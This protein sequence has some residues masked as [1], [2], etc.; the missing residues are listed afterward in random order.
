[1]IKNLVIVPARAGSIRLSNKNIAML[2]NKPLF[3][4]TINL[5]KKLK[6]Y[7]DVIVSTDCKKIIAFCKNKNY[8][9]CIKRKKNLSSRNTQIID[10]VLDVLKQIKENEYENIILLQTT[11]PL[12]KVLDVKKCINIFK[13]NNLK[14]LATIS[15]LIENPSD[16]ILKTK[17][18]FKFIKN[19]KSK[20]LNKDIFYV[21]GSIYISSIMFLKKYRTFLHDKYTKFIKLSNDFNVDIDYEHDLILAKYF[22][23]KQTAL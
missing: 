8:L 18:N 15:R 2:N 7:A 6:K 17:K 5:C 4:Y 3:L 9:K 21:D 12:R 13:R 10:V 14:S 11:S 22:L 23:K 20:K 16:L 19:Q 1:M